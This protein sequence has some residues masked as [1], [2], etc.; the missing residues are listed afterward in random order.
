MACQSASQAARRRASSSR[1]PTIPAPSRTIPQH[2]TA[3]AAVTVAW[4]AAWNGDVSARVS[5]QSAGPDGHRGPG[6]GARDDRDPPAAP[7]PAGGPPPGRHGHG[8]AVRLGRGGEQPGRDRVP[9]RV[10]RVRGGEG[11][12]EGQLPDRDGDQGGAEQE[13]HGQRGDD[14]GLGPV[15]GTPERI[16]VR[17]QSAHDRGG[18]RH[19]PTVATTRPRSHPLIGVISARSRGGCPRLAAGWLVTPGP[20][21]ARGPRAVRV[22]P[23]PRAAR[24]PALDSPADNRYLSDN[25]Y[26]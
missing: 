4:S 20:I 17:P 16:A 9:A 8:V 25:R 21:K 6:P 11:G 2:G 15:R 22:T 26:L 5:S 14:P 18:S 7:G 10:L 12:A 19:P 1:R 13:S 3:I 23:W 24:G